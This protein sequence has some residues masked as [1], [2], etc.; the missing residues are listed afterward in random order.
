MACLCVSSSKP[1]TDQRV[2][3]F[4]QATC[5]KVGPGVSRCECNYGWF[6]DGFN[7]S[8]KTPCL[9]HTDCDVNANCYNSEPG[10]VWFYSTH[11]FFCTSVTV[12]VLTIFFS[13]PLPEIQWSRGMLFLTVFH[14][15]VSNNIQH[16][17]CFLSIILTYP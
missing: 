16:N 5:T 12:F 4:F 3:V 10:Q 14:F 15:I 13:L 6:G 1:Q 8:P 9:D 17:A 7:C 11:A 2:L